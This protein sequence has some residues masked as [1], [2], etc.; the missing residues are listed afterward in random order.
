MRNRTIETNYRHAVER[1]APDD[2]ASILAAC[3]TTGGA[4]EASPEE[5]VIEMTAIRKPKKGWIAAGVSAAAAIALIAGTVFGL[6]RYNAY[7]RVDS[8]VALDVNPSLQLQVS[9]AERVVAAKALNADAHAILAGMELQGT[10]L[11]VA[12][13]AVIGS[14]LKQGYIG[15]EA[16]S[17]LVSVENPD[18]NKGATL[19]Q[20]LARE[21]DACLRANAVDGAIL[22]QTL[23]EDDSLRRL[24]EDNHISLGKAQLIQDLIRQ[25]D[26]LRFADLAKLSINDLNLLAAAQKATLKGLNVSGE[27]SDKAYIGGQKAQQIAFEHAGVLASAAAKM[28]VELD[29]EDGRM[30]YEVS[31]TVGQTEYAYDIDASSG[32]VVKYESG[33]QDDDED[34]SQGTQGSKPYIGPAKATQIALKHAGVASGDASGMKVELDT[35]DGAPVYE[36]EFRKGTTEY[37]YDIHAVSGTVL[38]YR[39][40]VKT[41]V[42]TTPAGTAATGL[43]G[44]DKARDIALKHAGLTTPGLNGL[45]VDL[46]E[47]DGVPVYEVEFRKGNTVYEYA[48]HAATGAVL[49]HS[50]QVRAGGAGD[51]GAKTT[52]AATTGKAV[53]IGLDRAQAIA[54][55]HA[56]LSAADVTGLKAKYDHEDGKDVYEVKF[57]QGGMEYDYEI[58]ALTGSIRKH[59]REQDD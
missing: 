9:P 10:D 51:S 52:A 11:N 29:C 40:K 21:I 19:Q 44:A 2:F 57:R 41:G 28:E 7:H 43:I 30:V 13:N 4:A 26:Q 16:N 25:N 59:D 1:A 37:D 46:D 24:A 48:I 20:K 42:G 6:S 36:V 3:D 47:E 15:T 23:E 27:A 18:S 34:K 45:E 58:D 49:E 12:V 33:R 55:D 17:I 54:L 5:K 39:S 38:R 14:M 56:G 31:F 53:A 35:D 8:I 32:A 22:S 50:R